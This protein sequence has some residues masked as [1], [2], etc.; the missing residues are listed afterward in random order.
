MIY[1]DTNDDFES[2]A[3]NVSGPPSKPKKKQWKGPFPKGSPEDTLNQLLTQYKEIDEA[4]QEVRD[5]GE[6]CYNDLQSSIGR[7]KKYT[8]L[9]T[10]DE[11]TNARILSEVQSIIAASMERKSRQ[12]ANII[13]LTCKFR[14]KARLLTQKSDLV[15]DPKHQ[16]PNLEKCCQTML[17]LYQKLVHEAKKKEKSEAMLREYQRDF[18]KKLSMISC[19]IQR[20]RCA[21]ADI[22]ADRYN[23]AVLTMRHKL[24]STFDLEDK[25]MKEEMQ[26]TEILYDSLSEDAS[27]SQE[28]KCANE[29][30]FAAVADEYQVLLD[31]VGDAKEDLEE[32]E[33]EARDLD[34]LFVEEA[35]LF[36][37]IE[38]ELKEFYEYFTQRPAIYSVQQAEKMSRFAGKA[39]ERLLSVADEIDAIFS[40][41]E[42]KNKIS[43]E[44]RIPFNVYSSHTLKATWT[45]WENTIRSACDMMQWLELQGKIATQLDAGLSGNFEKQLESLVLETRNLIADIVRDR[46]DKSLVVDKTST[47]HRVTRFERTF[48]K[49]CK[50]R[51]EKTNLIVESANSLHKRGQTTPQVIDLMNCWNHCIFTVLM[52]LDDAIYQCNLLELDSPT[53]EDIVKRKILLA[54][55]SVFYSN[56]GNRALCLRD[57]LKISEHGKVVFL[58]NNK[59]AAKD[60]NFKSD[61]DSALLQYSSKL[62]PYGRITCGAWLDMVYK[63]S[64]PDIRVPTLLLKKQEL[65]HNFSL[66][67]EGKPFLTEKALKRLT[68][69][70]AGL[71]EY[72]EKNV[73]EYFGPE[74]ERYAK[75]GITC[76]DYRRFIC[77]LLGLRRKL[78]V[79]PN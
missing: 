5:L 35:T 70:Y 31:E 44:H 76:Y 27:I 39:M 8:G 16:L 78:S 19:W 50:L 22:E 77:K 30:K 73:S 72:C 3:V 42:I 71:W 51:E 79:N 61:L 7:V 34:S 2:F 52:L 66:L 9:I 21:M 43:S 25:E 33:G 18:R 45:H 63:I 15:V 62:D 65:E 40:I 75:K 1:F 57:N 37:N 60:F 53:M 56:L 46:G 20:W 23:L 68:R 55:S 59:T 17:S 4:A 48:A 12:C 49:L 6:A 36:Q 10:T 14:S 29:D 32:L 41:E 13:Q 24:L 67:C 26:H 28:D 74:S 38:G 11:K 47:D 58:P 69:Q 64:H 54:Q